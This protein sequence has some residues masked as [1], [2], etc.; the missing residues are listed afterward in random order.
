M[1]CSNCGAVVSGHF[2]TF[3]AKCSGLVETGDI[4]H[5]GL[6]KNTSRHMLADACW[7]RTETLNPNSLVQGGRQ[8]GVDREL[9]QN[10]Y[11]ILGKVEADARAL[12]NRVL[13][14]F[15]GKEGV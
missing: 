3:E 5:K 11:D 7:M 12:F 2:C 9:K 4:S 1:F 6:L 15:P 14:V 13:T 8:S 10:T